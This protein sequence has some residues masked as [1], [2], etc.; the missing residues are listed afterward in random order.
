[1]RLLLRLPPVLVSFLV[2]S[3]GSDSGVTLP[4]RLEDGRVRL[5]NGWLLSPAGTQVDVGELPLNMAVSPDG[6]YIVTTDN[7]TG[8]QG[9]SVI[10][11]AAAT[12]V[13]QVTMPRAW[14]GLKFSRDGRRLYASGGNENRIYI[15]EFASGRLALSDS[16][17]LGLP[18]P[19]QKI[20]PAGL[21]LDETARRLY[22][23]CRENDSLYVLDLDSKAL[24]KRLK[25]PAMPYTCLLSRDGKRLYVSLW[26]GSAVAV[27]GTGRYDIRATVPVGDHPCDMVETADGSRLFVANANNNTV[28]A[29]DIAGQRVQEMLTTSL[30]P[31]APAGSTPNAVALSPDGKTLFIANADNNYL[32]LF[33]VEHPGTSRPLGFIPTGW[34]PTA[35]RALTDGRIAVANGKGLASQANPR[36]PNPVTRE[37]EPEYIGEL[38]GGTV[39][40]VDSSYRSRLPEYTRQVYANSLYDMKREYAR[41]AGHPIPEGA[42]ERSPIRHVFYVIKEN[43]TYDQVFG[44]IPE[45]NGDP[46]LCI[47]PDSITPNHHALAREFVL[48][49]NFYVDAE[50]SADGHNWSMGAY[51]TDYVEKSWP[52]MYGGRGGAYDYEGGRAIASPSGGYIWDNCLRNGVTFRS[53]GEFAENPSKPGD[54]ARATVPALEGRVAPFFRGWD[55]K[56]SDV[57]RVKEW[58]KEFDVYEREGGLPQ[59]QIIRLPNDHT[60]GTRKGSLTPRAY[61]AQNDL[62]LGMLVERISRSRYWRESAVFVL[63]DDAQDGADHVD[64]HRSIALV[65]SPWAKRK[66]KDSGMYSTSSMLRTMEL[67]LGLPPMTQF[68]AAATPMFGCFT[69]SADLT[70]YRARPASYDMFERNPDGAFGQARTEELDLT[71]EDA[72]PDREFSDII[73]R[74][75]RGAG[76]PM[77]AP[78]RSAFVRVDE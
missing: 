59:F 62:A 63:E 49:D 13:Q 60:E 70:P 35:V 41:E 18:W 71:K 57:D 75:V 45:G 46:A 40:I 14:L 9:L 11:C 23:V 61:L 48:L 38:F 8:A 7:G 26:G 36:G 19:K 25:L 10:D 77:P 52:T 21:D 43:R 1:M 72:I 37:S 56:Y 4:G 5:P 55:M 68:D 2:L 27:V 6:K 22:V 3:C 65:I 44:D 32:A 20:W 29:V 69:A 66:A 54:S 73:W 76:N 74:S 78:V 24:V 67:I 28:Y 58:M 16:I 17:V 12:R 42:G 53:Y 51:A 31:D 30:R 34:Y 39:S 47:F 15:Y 64:A 33:D 50:V